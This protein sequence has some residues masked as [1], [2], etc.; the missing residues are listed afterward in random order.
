MLFHRI[1][2]VLG[3]QDLLSR[4]RQAL[5]MALGIAIALSI[6]SILQAYRNG[7]AAEFGQ[8]QPNLLVV[9]AD[10]SFGEVYGSRISSQVGKQLS[11]M[12][13]GLVVPEIDD[14]T[15]TSVSNAIL[16][17]GIDLG[18]YTRVDAFSMVSGR[19]L[20]PGDPA[21]SAMLGSRLAASH[22]VAVG[23]QIVLRGRTFQVVGIFHSG[24]YS[25]NQAWISLA[26][27]Q[28]LLGWG[29]DVSVYII[30]DEGILHEGESLPGQI[31][32]TRRGEGARVTVYQYQPVLDIMGVVAF[33]MGIAIALTLTN[34]LWRL[35]WLRRREMAILRTLGFP[36]LSLAT[37]L[38]GQGIGVTGLGTLLGAVF[39]LGILSAVHVAAF[40][41]T[42]NPSLDA[43]TILT[44]LGWIGLVML[45]GIS[46]PAWW[47]SHL[48]LAKQLHSD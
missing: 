32:V 11:G 14:A 33:A 10:Q 16:V 12:G 25:D 40:G 15:G 34:V 22:N 28:A 9:Q 3:L 21:R 20:H 35:A 4:F 41:L 45:A 43:N 27:A 30:P 8:L 29:Q 6:F 24:T 23:G 13:I 17:R 38:L 48:N 5:A 2:F 7:L 39:T 44:S 36:A 47:L 37:Y 46:L 42:I 1:T 26:D 19:S 18:Q 31:S